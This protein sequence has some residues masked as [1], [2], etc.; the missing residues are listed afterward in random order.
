MRPN[1]S[2]KLHPANAVIYARVSSTAQVRKGQGLGSQETRCREFARMKGYEVDCVFADEA[3]SGGITTRPGMQS[4]LAYLG[5]HSGKCS[6]VVIIDDISRLARDIKAHLELRDAI[7]SVGARLESPSIEFGE[8]SDSILVENLLASVSQ[9]QRQKNAEQTKNRMRARA[10]NGYWVFGAPRGFAYLHKPGQGKV[11]VRDEPL[12]SII[13]EA[14]EGFASGR[15]GSQVEVKRFLERQP[16]YP[17]DLPNGEIR[18]QRVAELLTQPLYAGYMELPR[19]GVTFRKAQHEGLI[20]LATFEKIQELLRSGAKAPARKDIRSDFPLRGL[21]VCSDCETPLT[22]CW[23]TSKTGDKHAYYLCPKKGCASYRKSIRRTDLEGDFDALIAGI[24]PDGQTFERLVEELDA[25]ANGTASNSDDLRAEIKNRLTEIGA[26]IETLL[27]RIMEGKSETLVASYE[28]RV[29]KLER[30]KLL[31]NEKLGAHAK[32]RQRPSQEFEP[33]LGF[34]KN[35]M[36]LWR[37]DDLAR[38]QAVMKMLFA[39][40]PGYKKKI[41][42]RTPIYASPVNALAAI[43]GGKNEMARPGRLELPTF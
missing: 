33:A 43:S 16:D 34:L 38:K 20:A 42:V 26:Q 12:A 13:S 18:S 14:L 31:L 8:D 4:M 9:H 2:H 6:F 32:L 24:A 7:A 36:N 40:R 23:S 25:F 5:T 1:V 19:W 41:G 10:M 17:K 39:A 28:R 29:E 3:I 35:P 22:A 37:S 30:E 15:F 27:D 11:L 21:V